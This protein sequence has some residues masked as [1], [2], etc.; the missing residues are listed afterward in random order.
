MCGIFAVLGSTLQDLPAVARA[1]NNK[2][3]HRGPDADGLYLSPDSWA[4]LAFKRLAINDPVSGAQPMF[5]PPAGAAEPVI[6][7]ITNGEIYNHSVLRSTL[8]QGAVLPSSSD[9]EVMAPL[10]AKFANN[11]FAHEYTYV[12]NELKGVFATVVVNLQT[13]AFVAA[14]DPIGVRA[15]F[16]GSAAD[17]SIWFASEA[18]A[19]L[20]HC[21]RV[22]PFLP[23]SFLS[24]KKGQ[25]HA[26]LD[27]VTKA[28]FFQQ[29]YTPT[30]YNENWI[31][32]APVDLQQIHDSFTTSVTRR[33]MSD[34]PV[35]VFISGGL[36]SSIVASIAK[37]NLPADY[38]FHS[39]SC[40]L[41]GSPDIAAAQKVADYLGTEHHVLTFTVEDGINALESVIYHLETYDITT[42]RASTPMFLLSELCK[43]YVKVVLSGEGADEIL[44]GYLYFHNAPNEQ[45]FHEECVRRVKLLYT[46]DVLRGDRSTAAHN[47]ELRVPFLDRDFLDVT[48]SFSAKDKMC[49]QGKR[50]EKWAMREAFSKRFT[51]DEY[52]PDKI[53]HRPKEQFSDGV[54]Y[55]WIDGLKEYC[56]KVVSDEQLAAAATTFPHD[57][58]KT[59]EAYHYRV[60]FEKLFSKYPGTQGLREGV[61]KWIPRWSASEDPSGRAQRFH[62]S[63]YDDIVAAGK[64]A[65]VDVAAAL[66]VGMD[67]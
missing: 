2:L 67:E 31:P 28:P 34:V 51:G 64:Q 29:Y 38:V 11:G 45:E 52:L 56:E 9:C 21:D 15:M 40:G 37:R 8:L 30:Y 65:D 3:H 36:D 47:L 63:A 66:A 41:E 7:A 32:T 20:E 16:V 50:I 58:P 6:A 33:L 23:G 55:N 5:S 44:G 61:V 59:K 49:H 54:G 12:F 27:P 57:P 13:G 43:Q 18:K 46:A 60:I 22:D 26:C 48:M 14:R 53:L 62:A 19:L 24:G 4:A 25:E 10:V 1:C 35:G 42:I 17:G 39:F